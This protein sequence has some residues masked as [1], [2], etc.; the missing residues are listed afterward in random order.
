M[1]IFQCAISPCFLLQLGCIIEESSSDRFSD[2]CSH[3]VFDYRKC[4]VSKIDFNALT[5]FDKLV[6]DV[7]S[8]FHRSD[9]DEIL[10]APLGG[11]ICF[12]PLVE[13]V[14]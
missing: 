6:F 11:E 8:A 4:L 9:L 5:K 1:L 14:E 13:N 3:V 10:Q 12:L 7:S 2:I